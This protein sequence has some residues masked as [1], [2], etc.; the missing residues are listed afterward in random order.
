M[1]KELVLRLAYR[2]V[3]AAFF[4]SVAYFCLLHDKILVMC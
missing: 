2:N 4:L 1:N 3:V